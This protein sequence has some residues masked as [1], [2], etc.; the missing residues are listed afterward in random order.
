MEGDKM[1]DNMFR[2]TALFALLASVVLFLS[3]CVIDDNKLSF[4]TS[5]GNVIEVDYYDVVEEETEAGSKICICGAVHFR[6]LQLAADMW[7]DNEIRVESLKMVSGVNTEG[8][9]EFQD[10]LLGL[11]VVIDPIQVDQSVPG[12][13]LGLNCYSVLVTNTRT[14]EQCRISGRAGLFSGDTFTHEDFFA[15]RT[16]I[17][18]GT[19]TPEEKSAFKNDLRPQVVEN[20]G[21]VPM[22]NKFE[23]ALVANPQ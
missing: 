10:A 15:L 4:K 11:G 17:K 12:A 7:K 20:L 18:T 23:V 9:E 13:Y 2:K 14:G 19:A 16:K 6:A 1:K 22:K 21:N 5:E 8:P 3:G